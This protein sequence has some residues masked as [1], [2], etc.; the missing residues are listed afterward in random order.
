MPTDNLIQRADINQRL[1][2]ALDIKGQRSPVLQLD[3]IVSAV[4]IAEDLTRQQNFTEPTDRKLAAHG[5][6]A[7][8]AG[9]TVQLAVSNPAGSGVI[10]IIEAV[11][12]TTGTSEQFT[13]GLFDTAALPPT[14]ADLFF[15]DR[16]NSGAPTLRAFRDTDAVLRVVNRYL[17]WQ[18]SN[19]IST[20]WYYTDGCVILPGEAW[21][22]QGLLGGAAGVMT[23]W[24]T[25]VPIA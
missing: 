9:E 3:N 20:P 4:V 25:E 10:G 24:V 11:T 18:S 19:A 15:R 23:I 7:A 21:G 1:T 14:P 17:T 16:R 2:K 12:A 22:I 13:F 6:Q 5:D 8:V